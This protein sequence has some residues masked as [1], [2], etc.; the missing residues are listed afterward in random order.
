[1]NTLS[2]MILKIRIAIFVN[3]PLIKKNKMPNVS[4]PGTQ[5]PL[6]KYDGYHDVRSV[7]LTKF[8]NEKY[9]SI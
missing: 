9:S 4:F 1:M 5:I 3:I 7:R 2:Y 8:G 6:F